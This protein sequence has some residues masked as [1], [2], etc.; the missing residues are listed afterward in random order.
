MP[1]FLRLVEPRDPE[2]MANRFNLHRL[3]GYYF[4]QRMA[5]RMVE[6]MVKREAVCRAPA[7]TPRQRVQVE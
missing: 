3:L 1:G 4:L 5:K 6:C 2:G 7:T